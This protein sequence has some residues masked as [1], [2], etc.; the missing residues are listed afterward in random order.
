MSPDTF[1]L[2]ASCTVSL[3]TGYVIGTIC[4]SPL[5]YSKKRLHRSRKPFEKSSSPTTEE[6]LSEEL[7]EESESD[8]EEEDI[9]STSLNAIPGE[10]KMVLV[11]RTDLQMGKGKAAAQ[12]AHGALAAYK[13]ISTQG[14]PAYNPTLLKRWE[15]GGQAKITLKAESEEALDILFAQALSLNINARVIHDAGR[16]QIA[17]GSATVLAIGPAPKAILDQVT[18]SLKLY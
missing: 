10:V 7:S 5:K 2:V 6:S 1:T 18:G 16:T 15:L 3:I 8:Y 14:T 12:C 13:S 9:D 4:P 17:A 11:I